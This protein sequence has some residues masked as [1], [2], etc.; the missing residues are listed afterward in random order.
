MK[1]SN[2]FN[3]LII[4]T[5]FMI[6]CSSDHHEEFQG[7]IEVDNIYIASPYSGLLE[8]LAV[9]RGQEVKK[10]Q[11]L[12]QLDKNPEIL[13]LKEYEASIAQAE[14][15]LKDLENPKR[16]PEIAAIEAQ[17]EQIQANKKL[18]DIRLHRQEQLF[19][20]GAVNQDTVDE[21]KARF[22]DLLAQEIQ[23]EANLKLA[24]LGSR[25]EQIAAQKEQIKSLKERANQ[26]IWQIKQKQRESPFDGIIFDTYYR[27]GEFVGTAQSIV[28]LLTPENVYIEFFVPYETLT[29][30]KLGQIIHFHTG[31]KLKS[32][33]ATISYISP[34]AEYMP[35]L[36][37]SRENNDKLIFRIQAKFSEFNQYKP[38]QPVTVILP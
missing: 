7:Y 2:R 34:E 1:L 27:Q 19:V 36:I 30:L 24:K 16:P 25:D 21:A 17:I 26:A 35:P 22:Q 13:L 12:F 23:F 38:G 32:K 18:A 4:I 15:T 3:L 29:Y 10:G 33:E 28:S 37:Y 6:S 20:K 14:H 5:L 9:H 8:H 31:E 11:L